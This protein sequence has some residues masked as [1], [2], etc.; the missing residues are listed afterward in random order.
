M[1]KPMKIALPTIRKIIIKVQQIIA[2]FHLDAN[3]LVYF[4]SQTQPL[5]HRFCHQYIYSAHA[6]RS[7]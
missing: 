4:S 5:D 6:F 2:P 1:F 7:M 3:D